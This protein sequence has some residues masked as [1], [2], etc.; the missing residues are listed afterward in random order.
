MRE[1][2]SKF[3]NKEIAFILL[4]GLAAAGVVGATHI[5]IVN[6]TGLTNEIYIGEML[7]VGKE[8]GDY[9]APAAFA[10]GFLLARILEGH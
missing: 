9:A 8:T 2:L 3:L 4:L 6:G 7:R 1:K 10:V 5:F